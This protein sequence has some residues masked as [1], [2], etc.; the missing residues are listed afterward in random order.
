MPPKTQK[1]TNAAAGRKE[2]N[3]QDKTQNTLDNLFWKPKDTKRMIRW[4]IKQPL[5]DLNKDTLWQALVLHFK[6]DHV[7]YVI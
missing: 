5:I 6:I 4:W 2:D 3:N 7:S 1:K